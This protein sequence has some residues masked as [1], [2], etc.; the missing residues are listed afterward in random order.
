MFA[1]IPRRD[2][3]HLRLLRPE[4]APEGKATVCVCVSPFIFHVLILLLP[5]AIDTRT[6]CSDCGAEV[7]NWICLL[8]F[9][10]YC[11]RYVNEHMLRHGT[12]A[13]DHPLA[14]SFADLSVWCYG[15]DA[16]IDHPALHHYKNLVHQDKFHEP[17]VWSYGSDLVLDVVPG[18]A[19]RKAGQD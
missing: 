11:G 18:S 2:C 13:A 12:G 8:C 10:V 19:G 5:A 1:V 16:Y 9:G 3:P 15:C 14:L 17:L 6:P 7:E 4:T